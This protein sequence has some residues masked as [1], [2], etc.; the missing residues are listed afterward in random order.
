MR[1]PETRSAR[2]PR[3]APLPLHSGRSGLVPCALALTMVA[4]LGLA[5]PLRAGRLAGGSATHGDHP[6]SAMSPE[7]MRAHAEA[8]WASH[9][10]VGEAAQTTAIPAATFLVGNFFFDMDGNLAT[11]ADT[12][13]IHVGETVLWQWSA[14]FHTVT[15]GI[16]TIDPNAGTLFDQPS[17]SGHPSFA[18]QFNSAGTYPF[19]CSFHEASMKG[20]V[21]VSEVAGVGPA[22]GVPLGFLGT[23]AP[24]PTRA[25]TGFRFALRQA[26]HARAEVF[27]PSGRSVAVILDEDLPAGVHT[28]AWNGLAGG[29]PADPGAYFVRLTLP[30]FV[31]SRTLLVRR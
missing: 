9:A 18:F 16:S 22:G 27:D 21:V 10:P 28:A 6:G 14:G 15:S 24:N 29:A 23:L 5:G 20:V 2:T 7:A 8:W 26:G 31:G 1:A 12:A 19:F 17:D 13:R 11:L 4:A 25:G 3:P 30:G